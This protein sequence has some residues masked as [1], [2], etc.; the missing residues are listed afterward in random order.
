[1]FILKPGIPYDEE[2]KNKEM[3]I[4]DIHAH[5]FPD[6]IAQKAATSIGEFYHM[7]VARDGTIGQLL[8]LYQTAGISCGCIHSVA[9]TPHSVKSINRFIS[10]SVKKHPDRLVGCGAIHPGQENL[11]GFADEMRKQGLKGFKIHPDMQKFALDSRE[12]MEMFAAIEGKL[13]IIIHTGDPRYEYSRPRQM[14]HVL[15]AF[16]NLVCVCAHLGGWSEWDEAWKTLAGFENVYVDTSSSLYAMTP[17]EGR[18]IIR[19][20]SIERVLFGTDYPMW[21]PG[22]ELDRLHQ[23]GLKDTEE[24]RILSLNAKKLMGIE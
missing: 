1:M 5:V 18:R 14:K 3:Q 13:P 22:E 16:P 9:I 7:P 2:R 11:Q 19:R 12:A 15:D 8:Q 10:E 17:E 20:Y 6:A 21:N 24:E 4:I 23:L